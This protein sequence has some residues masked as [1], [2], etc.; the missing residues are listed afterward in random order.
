MIKNSCISIAFVGFLMSSFHVLA[1]EDAA[2]VLEDMSR[3]QLR[4]EIEKYENEFYRVF[5][6]S[7][8]DKAYEIHCERYTP[9][10]SSISVR[11]CE[12]TF[13]VAA[14]NENA[15]SSQL[16]LV[17]PMSPADIRKSLDVEFAKLTEMLNGVLAENEYFRALNADL[18]MLRQMLAEK[19]A[20]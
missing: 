10:S 7:I 14:R 13:V 18:S 8:A 17:M 19:D 6:S 20:Q 15:N 1:A 11:A 12:P 9:T 2:I 5:N 3:A 16:G 4:A